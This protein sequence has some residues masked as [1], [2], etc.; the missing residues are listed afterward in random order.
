MRRGLAGESARIRAFFAEAEKTEDPETPWWHPWRSAVWLVAVRFGSFIGRA[1]A[2]TALVSVPLVAAP[3]NAGDGPRIHVVFKGQRLGSIAKRY[4]VTVDQICEANR[5]RRKDP[6][7]PGQKLVIPDRG[8]N[9]VAAARREADKRRAAAKSKKQSETQPTKQAEAQPAKGNGKEA[10]EPSAPIKP[11]VHTV[12]RGQRLGSIAKRYNVAIDA[13]CH[14]NGIRRSNPIHPGQKLV[15]PARDDPDGKY[16][17]S[18]RLHGYLEPKKAD[19]DRSRPS[20]AKVHPTWERYQKSPWR[21]GYVELVGYNDRWKGYIIG[22]GN[23][24]LSG[25]RGKIS[26]LLNTPN[27]MQIHPRLIFLIAAISDTFGGRPF[28]IVSGYREH[29]YAAASRHRIGHAM[30][31]SIPGVPNSVLRD[32]LRTFKNV[33]VGYYPNSTFVHLDVRDYTAYWIDY[34]GPGEPPRYARP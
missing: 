12:G 22:P 34:S 27:D 10:Q 13:L 25:A 30:D 11:R 7:R 29:S 23:K 18:L 31:F 17:R 24:V 6:I 33:G 8:E 15:I 21:R 4:N 26:D 9:G 2:V 16:A 19:A 5:I 1:F 32:Y 14:A 20:R 3:A 28:R